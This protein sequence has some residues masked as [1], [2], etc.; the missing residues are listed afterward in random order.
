MNQLDKVVSEKELSLMVRQLA[1][2]KGF[3]VYHTACSM[4]SDPGFPDLTIAKKDRLIFAELKTEKGK[5]SQA[6]KDWLELLASTGKCE[7]F[8]WRPSSWP[9]I[10]EVLS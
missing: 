10:E 9:E 2:L 7:V 4:Y 6:Q 5:L 8:I 3:D 1:K